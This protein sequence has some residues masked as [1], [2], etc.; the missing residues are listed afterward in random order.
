MDKLSRSDF[1]VDVI[2]L[3]KN[4]DCEASILNLMGFSEVESIP[5]ANSREGKE[6]EK[7]T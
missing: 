3:L 6:R 4:N 2:E 7:K 1:I 5:H